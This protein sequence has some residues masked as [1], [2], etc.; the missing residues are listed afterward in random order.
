MLLGAGPLTHIPQTL[1]WLL[2][3]LPIYKSGQLKG[4]F[5]DIGC[6]H[7]IRCHKPASSA[8]NPQPKSRPQ[9]LTVPAAPNPAKDMQPLWPACCMLN[10]SSYNLLALQAAERHGAR[11][12]L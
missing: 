2:I 11:T 12:I 8:S 1:I 9:N 3:M 6:S 5:V 7:S 10:V 4:T